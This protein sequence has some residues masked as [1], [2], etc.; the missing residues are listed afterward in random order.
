MHPIVPIIMA[1]GAILFFVGIGI[2][3]R[4]G[5]QR[6][7][8]IK[9]RGK[10]Y[11]L[12]HFVVVTVG[13][14]VALI[15]LSVLIPKYISY[16]PE[17]TQQSSQPLVSS[18]LKYELD[19]ILSSMHLNDDAMMNAISRFQTEYQKASQK[20]DKNTMD[21]LVLEIA[22]RIR[23]ELQNRSYPENQV[24]REVERITGILK[25]SIKQENK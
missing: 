12:W 5:A 25:Q 2:Q 20:S 9:L 10:E 16:Q 22:Y 13:S 3:A 21:L 17:S 18:N 24:E 11:K 6:I 7:S 19:S 4:L 14:G 8:S 23:T 1:L 15:M